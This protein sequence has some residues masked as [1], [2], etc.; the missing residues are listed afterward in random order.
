M[1]TITH[2]GSNKAVEKSFNSF[3]W[4]NGCFN[5]D[6]GRAVKMRYRTRSCSTKIYSKKNRLETHTSGRFRNIGVYSPL[7]FFLMYPGSTN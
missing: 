3:F 5:E 4:N 6:A 7:L 2:T 1:S